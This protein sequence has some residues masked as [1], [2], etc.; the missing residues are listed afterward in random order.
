MDAMSITRTN[1]EP[2][3]STD[4]AA[5]FLGLSSGTLRNL[6]SQRRGPKY[7]RVL[8]RRV[9]YRRADL[10]RYLAQRLIDPEAQR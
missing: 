2:L 9:K 8:E 4:E 7:V 3:F 10:D 5:R 6:R 1:P